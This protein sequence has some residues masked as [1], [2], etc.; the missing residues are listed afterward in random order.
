MAQTEFQLVNK[1]DQVINEN[2][3]QAMQIMKKNNDLEN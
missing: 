3:S 2:E 1:I